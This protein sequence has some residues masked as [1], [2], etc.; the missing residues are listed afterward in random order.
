[1]GCGPV[2][3]D[4][5]PDAGLD[6]TCLAARTVPGQV[7]TLVEL[8]LASWGL[9]ALRDDVTLIASELATNAVRHTL[10]QE[11]RVRLTREAG[12][13][14]L[15]VW[16]SSDVLPVRKRTLETIAGDVSPDAS[17]LEMG[18]DDG[19]GGRGLPVVELLSSECGVTPT[20]PAGKWVW[21]RVTA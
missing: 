5:V 9:D 13:V 14:L 3:T 21:S 11:M 15:A 2:G 16:D 8:R 20:D 12:G 1:M 18:R 6:L 19:T 17:A 7:R 10:E 4:V